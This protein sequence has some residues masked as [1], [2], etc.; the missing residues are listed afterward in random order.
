VMST[1]GCLLTKEML[2]TY[3]CI[4]LHKTTGGGG[5]RDVDE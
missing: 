5:V 2:E 4:S 1:R 3:L